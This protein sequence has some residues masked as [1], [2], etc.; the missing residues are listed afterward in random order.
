MGDAGGA[1]SPHV[2]QKTLA[3]SVYTSLA[4]PT[5]LTGGLGHINGLSLPKGARAIHLGA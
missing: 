1:C 3:G 4:G 5:T 2:T